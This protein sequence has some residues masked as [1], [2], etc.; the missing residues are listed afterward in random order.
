[1][2]TFL[3][4]DDSKLARKKQVES[5]LEAG[6]EV[7]AEAENGL[8]GVEKYKE[9]NP[10]FVILDI[11]MPVMNGVEATKQIRLINPNARIIIASSVTNKTALTEVMNAGAMCHLKKP[12][13]S[14]MLQH[15]IMRVI[16]KGE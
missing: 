11:E 4:V 5:V 7:V 16:H 13:K 9:F 14:E 2:A 12:F 3:I 1:M 15:Q 10:D 6:H 8:D